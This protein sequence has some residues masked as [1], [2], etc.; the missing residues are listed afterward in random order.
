VN[1]VTPSLL[2]PLASLSLHLASPSDHKEI[3]SKEDHVV[4]V[5]QICSVIGPT[6]QSIHLPHALT[7]MVMHDE[8][9]LGQE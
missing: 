4:V 9:E 7:G 6:G 3:R 2:L 8:V 1:L 5:F